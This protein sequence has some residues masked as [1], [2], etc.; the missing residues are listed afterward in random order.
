MPQHLPRLPWID[1]LRASA[2]LLMILYHMA[3]DLK[4]YAHVP[5]DYHHPLWFSIGKASALLFIILSG[6]SAGLSQNPL[7]RGLQ[8]LAWGGVITLVTYLL[9]PNEFVRFGI[10][11]LL[12][13]GMLLS[14]YLLRLP[15]LI[16]LFIAS[17]IGAGGYWA[18]R[19]TVSPTWLLPFG[20]TYREFSSIDYYPLFPYLSATILGVLFFKYYENLA[21]EYKPATE[22]EKRTLIPPSRSGRLVE[23]LSKHSLAIYLIHQPLLVSGIF[24]LTHPIGAWGILFLIAALFSGYR[25]VAFIVH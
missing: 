12:G 22:G 3:Y 5:I 24:L 15:P 18:L 10:L 11:H 9:M 13:M 7:K 25:L 23:S 17:G 20:L 2:I 21:T 8:V 19:T 1:R 4:E 14:P 16:L 6:F